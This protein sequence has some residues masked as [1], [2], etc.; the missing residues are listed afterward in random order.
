M[1]ATAGERTGRIYGMLRNPAL[2]SGLMSLLGANRAQ[3]MLVDRLVQPRPGMT[4]LDVGAGTGTL[5]EHLGDVSYTALEP[6]PAY[7]ESIRARLRPG[8]RV[9]CGTTGDL[10][11]VS[12]R[13][14]RI[15]ILGVLHHLTDEEARSA[16]E[17]VSRLLASGGYL[18]T[19]DPVIHERQNRL[20]RHLA[21]RD[22]GQHVRDEP[23]YRALASP[24]F[25]A[26]KS[27]VTTNVL[28]VPYSHC[29]ML[30][31]VGG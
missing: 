30:C 1:T 24:S 9:W 28:T 27:A 3:R 5:R 20:A 8:D 4:I 22:R 6:N 26:V 12:E 25:A 16:L 13:F 11:D 23:A 31:S 7:C 17:S 2:Y 29:W 19:M 21:L 10:C 15:L 14:E 18:V